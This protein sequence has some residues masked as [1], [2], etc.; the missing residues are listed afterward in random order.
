MIILANCI[1]SPLAD[2]S[3]SLQQYLAMIVFGMFVLL[4]LSAGLLGGVD[5]TIDGVVVAYFSLPGSSATPYN[6]G[7]QHTLH[8][9]TRSG[10]V[11]AVHAGCCS[12]SI[13]VQPF[14]CWH[15]ACNGQLRRERQ[16]GIASALHTRP[17]P[18]P[19]LVLLQACSS[20][21]AY[22]AAADRCLQHLFMQPCIDP[23]ARTC[24]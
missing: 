13:G 9:P 7:K 3:V 22:T 21:V 18:A 1:K 6:L 15:V 20:L 10:I 24:R 23:G 12:Q 8:R 19:T 2:V 14:T 5:P 16:H 17:A 11:C 4:F